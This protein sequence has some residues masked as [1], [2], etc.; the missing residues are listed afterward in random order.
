V[1]RRGGDPLRFQ[2][3]RD[4][5][6]RKKVCLRGAGLP[7]QDLRKREPIRKENGKTHNEISKKVW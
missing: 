1:R 6:G 5:G 4:R 3:Q 7:H 2:R